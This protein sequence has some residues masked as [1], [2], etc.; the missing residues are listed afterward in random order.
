MA[1]FEPLIIAAGQIEQASGRRLELK[2]INLGPEVV[3]PVTSNTITITQSFHFLD[4]PV[5]GVQGLRTI[6]GG[7]EG[8]LLLVFGNN[9]RLRTVPAGNITM[10]DNFRLRQDESVLFIF[11]DTRWRQL[12]RMDYP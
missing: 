2:K 4:G 9:V 12:F 5:T 11:R 1:G 10:P 3:I 6:N 8:D 7:V